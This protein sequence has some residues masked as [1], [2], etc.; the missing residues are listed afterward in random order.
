MN[1]VVIETERPD[2]AAGV[3]TVLRRPFA[4]H[5]GVDS[6]VAAIRSSPR[7]RPALAF[8]ARAGEQVVGFVMLSGT[9]LVNRPAGER[10]EAAD[11]GI[12]IDLP[13]W[14]PPAAAQVFLLRAHDSSVR[15]HVEYPPA[16][17]AVS[18]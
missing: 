7:Y 6:L 4:H 16:I 18:S 3:A 15:G 5:P 17:A 9:D 1:N 8:V 10:R 13:E 12:T 14:A 2:D 11:H